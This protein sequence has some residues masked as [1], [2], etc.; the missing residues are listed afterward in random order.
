MEEDHVSLICI[1]SSLPNMRPFGSSLV[2]GS[3]GTQ[4]SRES[5]PMMGDPLGSSRVSSKKQNREGMVGAQSRQYLTTAKSS[6]GC[7]GD[8]SQDVTI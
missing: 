5:N 4:N 6:S 8:P 1:F 7:G 3:I 2:S